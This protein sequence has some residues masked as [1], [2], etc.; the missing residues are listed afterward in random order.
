MFK[1]LHL[2]IVVGIVLCATSTSAFPNSGPTQLERLNATDYL[3]D[4]SLGTFKVMPFKSCDKKLSSPHFKV[5][6]IESTV[7]EY[8]AINQDRT[9]KIKGLFSQKFPR[10]DPGRVQVLT[11]GPNVKWTPT[12]PEYYQL[13]KNNTYLLAEKEQTLKFTVL[14]D[15]LCLAGGQARMRIKVSDFGDDGKETMWS[16]TEFAVPFRGKSKT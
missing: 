15:T 12:D 3:T 14:P 13:C 7:P 10:K 5:L 9:L 16:C 6:S 8:A 1:A 2:C 11:D 4:Y